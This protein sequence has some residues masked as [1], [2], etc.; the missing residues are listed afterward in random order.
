M[1]KV[2]IFLHISEKSITFAVWEERNTKE[3]PPTH[4]EQVALNTL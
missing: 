4:H 2:M 3:K 1:L